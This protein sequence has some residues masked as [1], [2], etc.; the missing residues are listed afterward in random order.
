MV[1]GVGPVLR[2][3]FLDR[4]LTKGIT[5]LTGVTYHEVNPRGL[6]LTTKE[7][8][9]KIIEADTIILAAGAIPNR[10]LYGELK[11][12][13]PEIHL[14]GDCAEPRSIREAITDGFRVA[15]EI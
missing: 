1:L 15:W 11:G 12:K 2:S 14:V 8:G 10:K 9:I 4:L 6:L 7:G 13:V 3:F 5:L